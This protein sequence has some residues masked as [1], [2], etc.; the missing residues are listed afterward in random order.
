M[1]ME[2][3]EYYTQMLE[4]YTWKDDVLEIQQKMIQEIEE[5]RIEIIADHFQVDLSEF[6]EFL[7]SKKRKMEGEQND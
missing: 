2:P 5:K 1:N 7:E 4:T 6:H 3:F